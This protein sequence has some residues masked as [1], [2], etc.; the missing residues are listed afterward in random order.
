[1][2][3][4]QIY[5]LQ[6]ASDTNSNEWEWDSY[7]SE[8]LVEENCFE[9]D[10]G[11]DLVH[12]YGG[13]TS[14]TS[15]LKLESHSAKLDLTED[16]HELLMRGHSDESIV[17]DIDTH[18]ENFD[19][20]IMTLETLETSQP[21]D[22]LPLIHPELIDWENEGHTA[23][24]TFPND[25]AIS[26]YLNAIKPV[27]TLTRNVSNASSSQVGAKSPSRKS[28]NKENNIKSNVENHLLATLDPE[29]V[30]IK[31]ESN[32]EN[33]LEVLED[34]RFDTLPKHY[35]ERSSI[36]IESTE[37]VNIDTTKQPKILHPTT[38]LSKEEMQQYAEFLKRRQINF[39]WSYADMPGLDPELIMNHLNVNPRAK[40]VKQKL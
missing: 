35:Q 17:L 24:D 36:L 2:L 25:H 7:H 16:D 28:E 29:K 20:S 39:A 31:D 5:R 10:V 26:I 15:S 6:A 11:I 22:P 8:E 38:S 40:P 12:T 21:E 23:I 19:T 32:G 1:M 37:A 3:Y 27:T 33:L 18:I 34:G 4:D 13:Q 30:K 9:G 14:G